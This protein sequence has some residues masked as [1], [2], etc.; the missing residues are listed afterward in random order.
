MKMKMMME[1]LICLY[2]VMRNEIEVCQLIR[3]SKVIHVLV[4]MQAQPKCQLISNS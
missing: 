2:A 3:A 4:L 1:S